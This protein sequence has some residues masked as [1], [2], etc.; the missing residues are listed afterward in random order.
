MFGFYLNTYFIRE[1]EGV[2]FKSIQK[3]EFSLNSEKNWYL[4]LNSKIWIK[5]NW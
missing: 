5:S 3:L 1:L 2:I 4:N